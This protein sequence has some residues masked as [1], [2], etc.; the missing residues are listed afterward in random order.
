MS[1]GLKERSIEEISDPI[2]SVSNPDITRKI[3]NNNKDTFDFVAVE[4]LLRHDLGIQ[5][6]DAYVKENIE[7]FNK[8][9]LEKIATSKKY[10]KFG[11]PVEYLKLYSVGTH[12]KTE[13]RMMYEL[14]AMS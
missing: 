4:L 2:I 9:A 13:V 6:M 12:I 14:P 8:R 10:Q 5:D 7:M 1:S 3:G 11:V